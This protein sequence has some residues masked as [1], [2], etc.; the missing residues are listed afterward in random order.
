MKRILAFLLILCLLLAG[1]SDSGQAHIPTGDGLTWEDD[2]TGPVSTSPTEKPPQQLTLAY[3][4]DRSMNPYLCTDFTNRS[5]FSLLYQ[6]LFTVDR[7]YRVEP[8]LCK[9]YFVSKDMKTY[10]FYLE[11]AI[12]SDGHIL[13]ADDVVASLLAAKESTYYGG[14]FQHVT[15]IATAP[16]GGVTIQLDTP[17]ENLLILLDI[18]I[19]KAKD[20]AED[21]PLGTGPYTLYWT[22]GGESLQRR[23]NWWCKSDLVV[24]ADTIALLEAQSETHIRDNF[25]FYGLSLVCADPGSDKYADYRCDY[26]LWDCENGIFLYLATCE[27][28]PVFS[29]D[30]V[31]Q[32]LT[33]AI[34][35]NLLTE[36]YYRGFARSAT[37]PASPLSPYYQ[38]TLADKYAYKPQNFSQ[39]V[40]D[41]GLQGSSITFLVNAD[42]SLRVRVAREIGRM[43][44]DCGLEVTML[45]LRGNTYTETLK[46]W[47][48]DLYLGQ[49]KLSAN[50][51]LTAFFATY[52]S[53]S[54]GGVN[55]TAAYNLCLQ[56]L[57][58]HGNYYTLHKTIMDNGLLCPVLFRSYAVYAV[59]GLMTSLTP[60]RD[61]VF[62]YSMGKVLSAPTTQ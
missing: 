38:K 53:L 14:R 50:M 29:N 46:G 11:R 40:K 23:S 59:R 60:T 18:P 48:Y 37:L 62:H 41:A 24:T 61:S 49:T 35:R 33:Y 57:E 13:T 16:D 51:D 54:W 9:T 25:E 32:A 15:E 55:D 6:S 47:N 3:Y 36:N 19:V 58:N 42:D 34:D 4:K 22:T 28:S 17:Y 43:L 45:E 44:S 5:L 8:Q 12:F 7:D 1:C 2:Y 20:V 27:S 10:T 31:R 52:G 21:R 56:A 39:A 30:A 26:E